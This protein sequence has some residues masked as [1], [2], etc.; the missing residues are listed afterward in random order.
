[1]RAVLQKV[2]NASVTVDGEVVGKIGRGICV[3]V[4][5]SESDEAKDMDYI[6]R[7]ILS[8]RVFEDED[9]KMWSKNV[10]DLG[11]EVLCGSKPDFH[12]AMRSNRS[13]EF[14]EEFIRKLRAAYDSS[15]IQEGRFG[16]MMLV[17][18]ANDGPVTLQLDSR[19]F[20]YVSNGS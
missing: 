17:N 15:K 12:D 7:K 18:I 11:L 9:G 20:T 13:R 10:K 4:G 3:L 2:L 6:V 1:M 19:K 16:A 14:F 8:V 5:I